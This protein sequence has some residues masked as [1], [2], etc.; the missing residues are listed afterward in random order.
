MNRIGWT[1]VSFLRLGIAAWLAGLLAYL[2]ALAV[3]YGERISPGDLRAVVF[4]S[5]IAFAMCYWLVYLPV[6]RVL[7]RLLPGRSD[8]PFPLV[9]ILLGTVPTT[10][11]A[12]FLGGSLRALLTPEAILFF[13]LFGVVGLVIGVGFVRIS[14]I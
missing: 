7:Q 2:A 3:L 14:V 9:A 5:I 4:Y 10:L 11:I 1:F 6:L 12:F 13:V 8:W